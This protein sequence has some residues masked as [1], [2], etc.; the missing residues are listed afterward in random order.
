M[1]WRA[2]EVVRGLEQMNEERLRELGLS[3]L[4]KRR[5]KDGI[6]AAYSFLMGGCRGAGVTLFWEMCSEM[7][8]DN[9]GN[10]VDTKKK[11]LLWRWSNA[12]A[13]A[14]GG[15][16]IPFHGDSQN[17]VW[18]WCDWVGFGLGDLQGLLPAEIIVQVSVSFLFGQRENWRYLRAQTRTLPVGGTENGLC[19]Y[20]TLL[21]PSLPLR[22]TSLFPGK[23]CRH[24]IPQIFGNDMSL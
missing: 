16:W 6:I 13:G 10:W 2:T 24:V 17:Y 14:L 18:T 9:A 19:G 7:T 21:S 3:S 1:W 4:Q 20:V 11:F 23:Q 12:A 15:C 22:Y 8:K 5:V